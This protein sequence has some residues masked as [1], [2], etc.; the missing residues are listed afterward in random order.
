MAKFDMA[1]T[2]VQSSISGWSPRPLGKHTKLQV[3]LNLLSRRQS[4]H[5]ISVLGLRY[6]QD[7]LNKLGRIKKITIVGKS[8]TAPIFSTFMGCS[9]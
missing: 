9:F 1:M 5:L 8:K 6:Q 7:F 4:Q 2:K 3:N